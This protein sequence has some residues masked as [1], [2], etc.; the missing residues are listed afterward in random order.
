MT[1][2]RNEMI[3]IIK[4]DQQEKLP[5]D[6]LRYGRHIQEIKKVHLPFADYWCE[7]LDGKGNLSIP[8]IVFERK[9]IEDLF[10]TLTTGME[11]FQRE[12]QKAL[13]LNI[14]MYLI[15]EANISRVE[16]AI[17]GKTNGEQIL[18]TLMTLRVKYGVEPIFCN[19]RDE[20]ELQIVSTFLAV[21]RYWKR[22]KIVN[23]DMLT[24]KEE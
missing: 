20:M 16:G 24:I 8:R 6:F 12:I 23:D 21:R 15:I 2:L 9:S 17:I 14:Q 1:A 5:L 4:V 13:D 10:M 19:D 3:S 22:H 11:R 18:K 7:C